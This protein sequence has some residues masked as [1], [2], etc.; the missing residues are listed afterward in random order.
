[1]H[2]CYLST[3]SQN[4]CLASDTLR[5]QTSYICTFRSLL[6]NMRITEIRINGKARE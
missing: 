1:M 5:L 4:L 6:E 3:N 2:I